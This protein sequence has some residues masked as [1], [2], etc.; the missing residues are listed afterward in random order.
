MCDTTINGEVNK[1]PL[2]IQK[3]TYFLFSNKQSVF[4]YFFF[5]PDDEDSGKPQRVEA[6]VLY[7][8]CVLLGEMDPLVEAA[9]QFVKKD[10]AGNDASH[11]WLHIERVW[12]LAK[13]ILEK[14]KDTLNIADPVVVGT[15]FL[16]R[17]LS[18]N[19]RYFQ[20]R[21]CRSVT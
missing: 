10:V 8:S 4:I 3:N 20:N 19:K 15:F 1:S 13:H 5:L 21:A 9:I 11:D 12:R 7:S 2:Q 18:E 17:A 14:E 16:Y 6:S